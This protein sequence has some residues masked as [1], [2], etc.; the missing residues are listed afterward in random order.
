MGLTAAKE[1]SNELQEPRRGK[2]REVRV[3]MFFDEGSFVGKPRKFLQWVPWIPEFPFQLAR[4]V[5][6]LSGPLVNP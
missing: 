3:S 1:K 5:E 4:E 6:S 2:N